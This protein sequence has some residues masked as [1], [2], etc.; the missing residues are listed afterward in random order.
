VALAAQRVPATADPPAVVSGDQSA[1]PRARQPILEW[2]RQQSEATQAQAAGRSVYD[3]S[4]VPPQ[5]VL[6]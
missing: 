3:T 2:S 1:A 6:R 5:N 4:A